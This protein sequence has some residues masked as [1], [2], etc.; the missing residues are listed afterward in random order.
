MPEATGPGAPERGMIQPHRYLPIHLL[1]F[2]WI[3]QAVSLFGDRLNNF[4]LVALINKFAEDPGM[5]LSKVYLAMYLPIFVLAPLIGI[6]L[7]KLDK[8]WVLV[9]T[10]ALRGALV[11]LIPPLFALTGS[12]LP[13]YGLIFLLATGNL[14]FLPAK[15]GLV[16]ELVPEDR[17]VKI[18]STLWVAGIIG[19]IGGFLGGGF[20]FDY[21]SW[22]TCFYLDGA[23]YLLSAALLVSI[24][25]HRRGGEPGVKRK[26]AGSITVAAALREGFKA[27][28]GSRDIREP[29]GLQT[30]IFFA[31]GG[32]SVLAIVLIGEASPPGSSLGLSVTGLSVG[33]GMGVG[34]IVANRLPSDRRFRSRIEAALLF[35]FVPGTAVIAA[36]GLWLI[37]AGAFACGLAASPLMI[38][39]ESELQRAIS[40]G[41]RGRIFSFREILTRSFFLLSAFL[42]SAL[43]ESAGRGLMLFL[44]GLFLALSGIIWVLAQRAGRDR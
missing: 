10:D 6:L 1:T 26:D 34:S 30:L 19:V 28:R 8:R 29:L 36:G 2:F 7:D 15:S 24:A 44:L 37:C 38:I 20:I 22:R 21:L 13:V 5:T 31:A 33:L 40:N 3:A 43:G 35:L 17:L 12:F 16:P 23:T 32:F 18:N 14:F 9:V 41:M 11:M 27:V 42:F 39:S 4:S 25:V